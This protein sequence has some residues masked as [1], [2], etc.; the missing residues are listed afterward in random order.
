M[1]APRLLRAQLTQDR[2]MHQSSAVLF[3]KI[4]KR[5]TS[6][7][8]TKTVARTKV[9]VVTIKTVRPR[10]SSPVMGDIGKLSARYLQLIEALSVL[11]SHGWQRFQAS[12][13]VES[14]GLLS[15]PT[16]S[17]VLGRRPEKRE[18][19]ISSGLVVYATRR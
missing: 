7:A 2:M 11:T 10:E 18:I 13:G 5:L 8:A 16:S 14:C 17:G 6:L 9:V 15:T 3:F 12:I 4:Q 1:P 19:C